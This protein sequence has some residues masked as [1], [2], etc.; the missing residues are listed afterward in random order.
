MR[1]S[2]RPLLLALALFGCNANGSALP[3]EYRSIEVPRA[4]LD[5]PGSRLEGRAIYLEHCA[6]C[7]GERADGHGVRRNLS[8]RPVDFTDVAWRE[9]TSARRVFFVVREG[10]RGTAM[11]GWKTLDEEET[12]DVVAYVLSVAEPES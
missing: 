7:H 11:A 10:V 6:L 8:S 9:R 5:S 12:W 3:A 4:R 2:I 1:Q